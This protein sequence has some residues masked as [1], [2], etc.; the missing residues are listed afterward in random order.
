HVNSND[1]KLIYLILDTNIWL[2]LA[3]GLD[4]LTEKLHED[5]H[6]K[7]LAELKELKNNNDICI[8]INDIVLEEWKRNKEHSK[9]KIK[10]LTNKLNNSDSS[11]NDLKKYVKSE[12]EGLK[13]EYIEGLKQDISANE[14]HIQKVENFL[15]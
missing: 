2:Y 12:T 7:L 5:L 9:L 10:K 11:F 4:P 3:N 8:L 15:F 13:K 14:E 6:F 1:K